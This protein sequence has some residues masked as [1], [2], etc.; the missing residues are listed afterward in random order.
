MF[1]AAERGEI[2]LGGCIVGDESPEFECPACGAKL[3]WVERG[4]RVEGIAS[5]MVS[6]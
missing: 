3:P 4:Q 5:V 2:A 1:R 6:R